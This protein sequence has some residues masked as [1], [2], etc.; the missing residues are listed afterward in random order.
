[1]I[2]AFKGAFIK[3]LLYSDIVCMTQSIWTSTMMKLSIANIFLCRK[4]NHDAHQFPTRVPLTTLFAWEKV[5][6]VNLKFSWWIIIEEIFYAFSSLKA[7]K[8]TK[9][10]DIF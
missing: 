4:I 7:L 5:M 9:F 10:Q 6:K 1:M 8:L 3:K 2:D